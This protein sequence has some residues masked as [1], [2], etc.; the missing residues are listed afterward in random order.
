MKIAIREWLK[1]KKSCVA[2]IVYFFSKIGY[3]ALNA[4]IVIIISNTISNL[5]Y[6]Q[7]NLI[8]L[9]IV[10]IINSIFSVII[11]VSRN[12]AMT[13]NFTDIIDRYVDKIIDSDYN[14][15]TKF[16]CAHIT[17]VL[18]YIRRISQIGGILVDFCLQ[19]INV[20]ITLLSIYII[21]GSIVFPIIIVYTIGIITMKFLYYKYNILDQ[22]LNKITKNQNQEIE[23]I[24]NGFTEVRSFNTEEYHRKIIRK[25]NKEC[26][27]IKIKKNK[28]NCILSMIIESTDTIGLLIV[29]VYTSKQLIANIITQ[30]QAMSIV[31]YI[32]R[33][34]YPMIN[35]L[36]F[37]DELSENLSITNE[38]DEIINYKNKLMH[39]GTIDLKG[40]KNEICIN[41][42]S[43]SYES[44]NNALKNI[45]IKI[46]KGMKVGICG[47]SGGGKSTL[48][49]ILNKFYIPTS[50]TITID[51]FDIN[52]LTEQSYRKHICSVYQ[53]NTIFPGTIRENILYG[54]YDVSDQD[55]IEACCKAQL[56]NFIMSLPNKFNTEVGPKGL[57]LSGGQKQRISLARL[58]LTNPEIILLDEATSALDNENETFIQEAI[59]SL[60]GKTIITIAHRL[61]TIKN[62]D[63]IYVM[64]NNS[65][66]EVGT[67]DELITKKGVYYK[68]YK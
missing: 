17:T 2:L 62:C 46:K 33:L 32:F 50:G 43:F 42:L 18:G 10:C 67:H 44:A 7:K 20:M 23:N 55:L 49:K 60:N 40:F 58:F 39:N 31:M 37:I 61:S 53:E 6:L 68:M 1:N 64:G 65:I 22:I 24:I 5:I 25:L 48:F 63:V 9:G 47:A 36:N 59:D 11:S 57:K 12:L 51:G 4:W 66:L 41:N 15:F 34:I 52:D 56:Y 3:M 27:N 54:N 8:L 14:M 30:T 38:Y 35:I 13:I 19:I 29:I 16:S 21:G 28:I 45:N 26:F